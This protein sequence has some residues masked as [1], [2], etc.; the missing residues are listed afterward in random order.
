MTNTVTEVPAT[1]KDLVDRMGANTKPLPLSYYT[2]AYL[3]EAYD[4]P[5][6]RPLCL[7]FNGHTSHGSVKNDSIALA[8]AVIGMA[9]DREDHNIPNHAGRVANALNH[10]RRKGNI[11]P[12]QL[13]VQQAA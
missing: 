10:N 7:A 4:N 11:G 9:E 2:R 1:G 13:A 3:V 6:L 8:I 12:K 5:K